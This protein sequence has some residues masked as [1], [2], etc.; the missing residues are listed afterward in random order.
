MNKQT[1][2]KTKLMS[3]SISALLVF[4]L[5][6]GLVKGQDNDPNMGI[7]PVPASIKKGT[8]TFVFTQLTTIRADKPTDKA[9][10]Y[11][12]DYLLNN[13]FKNK[14]LTY[15]PKTTKTS[16][17]TS[18]I[19]TSIGS[20]GIP[21]EGYRLTVTPDKI[22]IIGKGAGLFYGIQTFLQL[23][24]IEYQDVVKIN[25]VTIEDSPRFGY[26]G[27]ML[28]VS[29][30]FFNVQEV[31]KVIDMLALYKINNFHWHLVDGAGWRIEI[32]KYPKLTEVGGTRLQTNF[33][34][35]RDY[36][37]NVPY[38]GF[39][40]QDEIREVVKYAADRYINI[41]PEIEMPAHSDAALRAYPELKCLG[42]DG[43]DR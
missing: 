32:R 23:F 21:E 29:R 42:V 27:M 38:T 43:T 6:I 35:N 2:I 14:I 18:V 4:I 15:N 37:D 17:G 25:A 24:P 3:V 28:D 16:A 9:I 1:N 40:T 7:I 19:L 33:G 39:Y 26:R 13:H 8:G 31:K 34:G 5:Q 11:L 20:D 22:T 12:K 10:L 30:H 36:L 41:V